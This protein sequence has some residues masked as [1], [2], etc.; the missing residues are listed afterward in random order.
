MEELSFGIGDLLWPKFGQSGGAHMR[1][2]KTKCFCGGKRS[3][4]VCRSDNRESVVNLLAASGKYKYIAKGLSVRMCSR[5]GVGFTSP[6]PD[7][8]ML[9]LYYKGAYRK[10]PDGQSPKGLWDNQVKR[11]EELKSWLDGAPRERAA[12]IGCGSGGVLAGLGLTGT[13]YDLDDEYL[14]VGTG[15]GMD[16][17]KGGLESV[18]GEHDLLILRHVLEHL[19]DPV[20]ALRK[21]RSLLQDGGHLLL[22]IPNSYVEWGM[23]R[24]HNILPHKWHLDK[25]VLEELISSSGFEV[26]KLEVS[27]F[28]RV[29]A[30]R[31][32]VPRS[33]RPPYSRMKM[34]VKH[35]VL[36]SYRAKTKAVRIAERLEALDGDRR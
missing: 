28:L 6:Y 4:F 7:R 31:N 27:D 3:W 33:F 30:V 2:E 22:E 23:P 12:D 20:E 13:G 34:L 9:E 19:Y 15:N 14:E 8:E 18:K 10:E 5:C 24:E 21:C 11:G 35:L 1:L 25:A 17:Q 32:G 29:L 16:L 26:R 36:L